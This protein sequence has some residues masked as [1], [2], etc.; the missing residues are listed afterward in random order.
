MK[1]AKIVLLCLIT[2]MALDLTTALVI[3]NADENC[4]MPLQSCSPAQI[5]YGLCSEGK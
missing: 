1:I 3:C 5:R 4:R 2:F